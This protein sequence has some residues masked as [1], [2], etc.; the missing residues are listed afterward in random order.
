MKNNVSYSV[1]KRVIDS[2][3]KDELKHLVE[4]R[5]ID[6]GWWTHFY[7]IEEMTEH[8][9]QE[10]LDKSDDELTED[11]RIDLHPLKMGDLLSE[12]ADGYYRGAKNLLNAICQE[13]LISDS[14]ALPALMLVNQFIELTL[15]AGLQYM[16][17]YHNELGNSLP[18]INLNT[19]DLSY[20]L[21][22]LVSLFE[23]GKFPLSDDTQ[24]FIL[25]MHNINENAEAFRYPFSSK[26]KRGQQVD[27]VFHVDAPPIPLGLLK[28][29]V[30]V[31][32]WELS[33]F[34]LM[35]EQRLFYVENLDNDSSK[36]V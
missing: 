32:G 23:H 27:L 8:E 5:A 7:G 6:L 28:A 18:E 17:V 16:I 15:K 1:S 29:E 26:M 24:E 20:L 30:H 35:F 3:S 25:K 2:L 13:K 10:I 34:L 31:Y 4:V 22:K 12:Y 11:W 21:S 19:H 9:I 14:E 33:A 36:A